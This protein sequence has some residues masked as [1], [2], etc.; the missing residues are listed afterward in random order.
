MDNGALLRRV[1]KEWERRASSEYVS[2]AHAHELTLWL[3]QIGAPPDLV[4]D[5]IRVVQDELLHSE[6]CQAASVAAGGQDV[7]QIDRALLSLPQTSNHELDVLMTA[8]KLFCLGETLAVRMFTHARRTCTQ[9]DARRALDRI[10]IDEPRHRSFGWDLL[11]WF[12]QSDR[13]DEY[14][15][16]LATGLPQLVT[17]FL[18]W[19]SPD[20]TSDDIDPFEL[21]WG[22]MS[23]GEA[24]AHVARV[25]RHDWRKR[26]EI[27]AIE[28]PSALSAV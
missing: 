17:A 1:A 20:T 15:S 10:V 5:G 11:D 16:A 25:H 7:P 9:P 28:Y 3:I 12:L 27:R 22:L 6:L 13:A 26:F 19:Y 18:Q 23:I 8:V 24:K 4:R 14:R 21:A 2:A